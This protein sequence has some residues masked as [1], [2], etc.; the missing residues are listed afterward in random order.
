MTS[1]RLSDFNI[2]ILDAQNKDRQ[3]VLKAL[4]SLSHTEKFV[5]T[6]YLDSLATEQIF[7]TVQNLIALK[8]S[9]ERY[10]LTRSLL[11]FADHNK[12]LS[13]TIPA[14]PSLESLT[15]DRSV[16]NS[17][18]VIAAL[19]TSISDMIKNYIT[20]IKDRVKNFLS[21]LTKKKEKGNETKLYL[22]KIEDMMN[23]GR[24]IDENCV[25]NYR[26]KVFESQFVYK[27]LKDTDLYHNAFQQMLIK[28]PPTT[29]ESYT[30]WVKDLQNHFNPI[31]KD[32]NIYID[33]HG[34]WE[35]IDNDHSGEDPE[36]GKKTITELG[37]K[38]SDI[39]SLIE[40]YK[41]TTSNL[42]K[43]DGYI[44]SFSDKI[45]YAITDQESKEWCSYAEN[46]YVSILEVLSDH[47]CHILDT[48]L[49]AI[50]AIFHCTKKN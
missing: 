49:D 11:S 39:H 48:A 42:S 36:Y 40:L 19:E 45:E 34:S 47:T 12:I 10:G 22:K 20:K 38:I 18:S 33:D 25:N 21:R 4:T 24:V 37:Y 43:Y 50:K 8:T 7:Q 3:S 14:I 1:K 31:I 26:P 44:R 13:S 23:E 15:T 27:I 32:I 35:I 2:D 17:S 9:I 29:E 28:N 46:N 41:K 30:A 16:K 6:R 5:P